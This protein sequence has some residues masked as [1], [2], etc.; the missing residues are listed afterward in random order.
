MIPNVHKVASNLTVRV[1]QTKKLKAGMISLSVV[2]PIDRENTYLT[3]LLLSV[4]HRGTRT[5]PTIADLNRRLDYLFGTELS[6]KNDY[7][8]DRHVIGISADLLGEEYLPKDCRGRLMEDVLG[9]MYEILFHPRLDEN[10]YFLSHYVES[11]KNLQ[12]DA[13]AALRNS[14]RA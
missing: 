11:E 14:P 13:I 10:G 3:S 6:V 8:G 7:R 4:L 2:L 5:Y 12:C 1:C 9:V